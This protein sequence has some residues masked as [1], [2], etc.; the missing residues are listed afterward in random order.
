[1]AVIL[2]AWG[3]KVLPLIRGGRLAVRRKAIGGLSEMVIYLVLISLAFIFTYPLLYMIVRSLMSGGDLSDATVQW[4]PKAPTLDNYVEAVKR[5]KYLQGFGNSVF[6]SVGTALL[7]A[8]SCSFVGYGF[9]RYRFP[10]YSILLAL[11]LFTFLVPPT[12]MIVPLYLYMHK[13]GWISTY[14]PFFVPSLLAQGLRGALFV[15]IFLQF[16]RKL[17]FALEESAR[18]DGAGALRTYWSIMLPLA[19]PAIIVVVLFSIVWHWNDVFE[20]FLYLEKTV[21]YN[22]SQ[23]LAV[24]NAQGDMELAAGA[25]S[26][27]SKSELLA[28]IP[29]DQS[30]RMAGAFLT[31]VPVLLLY[32]VAQR[33]FVEGVER[34][35]ISGE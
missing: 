27:L 23:N 16:F 30:R 33:H 31:I 32:L 20:P 1:M 22:L 9:A 26:G 13:I 10:G 19:R 35:G 24:M 34:S 3:G 4:I 25:S 2:K 8:I 5:M 12:T 21:Y 6:I 15:L 28:T 11:V 18:I 29:L 17:P 14:Y 7:Q